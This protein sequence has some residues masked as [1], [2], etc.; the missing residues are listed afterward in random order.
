MTL[1][2]ILLPGLFIFFMALAAPAF[3]QRPGPVKDPNKIRTTPKPTTGDP[4][5]QKTRTN[6]V[7][8]SPTYQKTRT[9]SN[10]FL[11]GEGAAKGKKAYFAPTL[12]WNDFDQFMI[13]ASV[14]SSPIYADKFEYSFIPMFAFGSKSVSGT[15]DFRYNFV[16]TEDRS[17][18]G[19][20]GFNLKSFNFLKDTLNGNKLARFFKITPYANYSFGSPTTA[21]QGDFKLQ[22]MVI[23]EQNWK[24]NA[25][26]TGGSPDYTSGFKSRWTNRLS[27]NLVSRSERTPG[28]LVVLAEHATY[29]NGFD[30]SETFVKLS[31]EGKMDFRFDRYKAVSVRIFAAGYPVHT[32]RDYG[33]Y[34]LQLVSQRNTD[35][36]YDDYYF[37]RSAGTGVVARQVTIREGGFKTPL[38]DQ[39]LADVSRGT[40]NSFVAA[41]NITS[42]IPLN[43]PFGIAE[44]QLKPYID[45]GYAKGTDPVFLNSFQGGSPG[46]ADQFF[47]NGGIM[48]DIDGGRAAIFIPFFSSPNLREMFK[49]F[50]TSYFQRIGFQIDL[51]AINPTENLRKRI[52]DGEF[53]LF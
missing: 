36:Q 42:H 6:A 33:Q 44:L 47:Y 51:Q 41:V 18:M 5:G 21:I 39:S 31:V 45:F 22:S 38:P 7:Y 14:H 4:V 50:Y 19:T 27:F 52:R 1:Q 8:H 3:A 11:F 15:G 17:R 28:Q 37:N 12:S 43:I 29:K 25:D 46:F 32:N 34:P 40:S 26:T 49:T 23:M 20:A 16:R 10:K 30:D 24:T 9:K 48:I 13:G 2:K 35:Y 53:K